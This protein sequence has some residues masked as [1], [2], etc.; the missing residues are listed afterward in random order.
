MSS[1]PIIIHYH[2]FKNA[3]SSVDLALKRLFGEA[4]STFEGDDAHTILSV[5]DIR[6]YLAGRPELKAISSHVLRPPLPNDNCLPIVFLRHPILRAKSVYEFCKKDNTQ[7]NHEK[8]LNG[9]REYIR[10]ALSENDEGG[11]VIKNYQVIHLSDASFREKSILSAE[12]NTS[13]LQQAE[14]LLFSWPVFGVVEYYEKSIALFN[15]YYGRYFD[16]KTLEVEWVNKS[17]NKIINVS[18]DAQLE[19]IRMDLGD[20]LYNELCLANS[21]DLNLYHSCL[22]R[23]IENVSCTT[24]QQIS[25]N[26]MK[27]TGERYVPAEQGKIRLE[28]YHRYGIVQDIVNQKDVLD[29]ACG[30]GYGSS[31]MADVAR[32]VVGVDISDE[33][34]QNA[35]TVYSKANLT[36][37]QG[38]AIALDFANASFDVVVSFETIE[39]LAEQAEMLA[40][41]RRVLRPNGL[42][43]I[44]SPN[45]PIYSEES[46]EHN[47]FHVKELDFNEFD[48][49]LKVQFPAIKYFGQR[50]LMGSVIQ[51]L[52]GGQD[53]Y[54]AWHDDGNK[55]KP[56]TGHL[57]DPVYFVAVCGVTVSDLPKID[58]SFI[59][60][61]NID[62]IKHYVSFANWAKSLEQ[63]IVVRDDLRHSLELEVKERTEWAQALEQE[64]NDRNAL[65]RTLQ[66]EV[67]ERTEWA[68]ALEQESNDRNALIK[69]LQAELGESTA[70]GL[71]QDQDLKERT[72]LIEQLQAEFKERTEWALA[73]EQ[74][75]NDRH[76]LIKTL[77]AELSE[78]TAWGLA[79]DQDLKERAALIAQL[80]AEVKERT[81]WVQALDQE[82]SERDEAAIQSLQHTTKEYDE[83]IQLL[84]HGLTERDSQIT[85]YTQTVAEWEGHS[86][87]LDQAIAERD[88]YIVSLN[89]SIAER[90]RHI[91]ASTSWRITLPLREA[92][93]FWILPP[94]QQAKR[95]I[96]GSL[97]LARRLYQ[98]LP[99]SCEIKEAHRKSLA[100]YIPRLLLVSGCNPAAL[101]KSVMSITEQ[102]MPEQSA[103]PADIA[104]SIE[105]AELAISVAEQA[106][107]EQIANPVEFAASIEIPAWDTPL[108]SFIIPI[109]G[110]LDYTLRCLASITANLPQAKFEVIIVDDCS[111]DNSAEVLANVKGIRL[112]RNAHNQ[113][114]IRSCNTAANAA[115]GDYLYFL[116]NDTE[117]TP[118]WLDELLRT[119]YEF[120]GTGLVGSKLIYP[121]GRLQEAGGIIWQDGSAWN[122]GR[123]QDPL[124]PV[125][126]YAREV[127][128]CSGA[129]IMVPKALFAELGG[130]DE[131][132]L[133]AYCEDSD[134]ALKI[135]DKGYRVLYQPMSTVIHYEGITSGTDTSGGIKAYQI[136]NSKKLFARW[137]NRLQTHQPNG[138]DVDKAK[139]R[140]AKRRVLVLEHCTLTPN[141]DAGSVTVFNLIFLLREM[142][143]QVTFIPEDNF[144]YMPEHTT[145]LQRIGVEVLYAPYVTS[146]EQHVQEFGGRYDLVFLFRPIVAERHLSCIRK[147][148][149][150]AK[151]LYH[152]VDLHFLRMSR[153]AELQADIEK[154]NEA[155]EMKVRELAIIQASD[156]SIVHSVAELELLHPELPDVKLHV[157]PLILDIQGTNKIFTERQDI[158]FVGGYQHAPNVDAVHYFV[159]DI[160]PL[161]RQ[162]LPG[163]CFYAIGSKVPP[164]IEALA[165]KDVIITGFIEDLNPLLNKMRISV[166]PLRYG[167]GI[168]GKIGSAMAVGLPVVATNL[169]AEGMSLTD[170]KNIMV[171]ETSQQFADAVAKL[172]LDE[173]LWNEISQNSIVFAENAWGAEAA[174]NI[175]SGILSELGFDTIRHKRE[176]TMYKLG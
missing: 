173:A 78:S 13:D 115:Q 34:V 51:P 6:K 125:F 170:G 68:Q 102:A 148:C 152:T 32:S 12:A 45:R 117:V 46:G 134:L 165:A 30:E 145:A 158:V 156:A 124:L 14:T 105:I 41:I 127:D 52:E 43:V 169:A 26:K 73:L 86:A 118:G 144:L 128:Y 7:F 37:Q 70:W 38:S 67:K 109:Y 121:D 151:V 143:F 176:L 17:W 163:V 31:F 122:F 16:K 2:I 131:H 80:Q 22:K 98:T 104:A 28:H 76:A 40:E 54:R 15:S 74:E 9:F 39:H 59:Y 113:G 57:V 85:R 53:S 21:L 83:L 110:Q 69:T 5:E 62:L 162:H 35:S 147:Y 75:S 149:Q 23:F 150:K 19:Q 160:M 47:E 3:G 154:Q 167:A 58:S 172:Y 161:L 99:L 60:P 135:R 96:R 65:I 126:N 155:D 132:Y 166:A 138:I 140:T 111:P 174:W 129:S 49:L 79:Q 116:N 137:K 72:A 33:A 153:E 84:Q 77:Q 64:S 42:L 130:F 81:E 55:L 139:D 101:T 90:D 1:Y 50:M 63:E 97:R 8:T 146:V 168:K 88:G 11:I 95:Y 93:H 100:K 112:I 106:M 175:F 82:L 107:P 119:F 66:A 159:T 133:P 123:L 4:W 27:F 20:D 92:K 61:D 91:A 44:S 164:E 171:A 48:E 142:D 24:H 25:I 87:K 103:D 94:Q 36:F 71:A 18:I 120:P 10:W 89:Q 136:D 114:F 29:L 157:F 108:V 141:E 56:N